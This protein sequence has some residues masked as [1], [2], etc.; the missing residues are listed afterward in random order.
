MTEFLVQQY[1]D[2]SEQRVNE[3]YSLL[4]T[5]PNLKW[6]APDLEI[7]DIAARL[8]AEHRLRTPDSLQAATR[9]VTNDPA[10]AEPRL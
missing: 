8:R 6:I 9:L 5:Y 3:F 7:A 2:S 10:K 4:T 1:R